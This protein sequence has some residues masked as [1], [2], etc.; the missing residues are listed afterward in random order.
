VPTN[1]KDS[2][3][4]SSDPF[5]FLGPSFLGVRREKAVSAQAA[6]WVR[7]KKSFA[8]DRVVTYQLPLCSSVFHSRDARRLRLSEF[9]QISESF[10]KSVNLKYQRAECSFS[11]NTRS[12]Q[13]W[14]RLFTF[15]CM[16]ALHMLLGWNGTWVM[17]LLLY[18]ISIIVVITRFCRDMC[19]VAFTPVLSRIEF[20][21]EYALFWVCF[22]QT[23]TQTLTILLRFCADICTK[24]WLLASLFHRLKEAKDFLGSYFRLGFRDLASQ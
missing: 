17:I 13:T 7:P 19:F 1:W 21:R 11:W 9:V 20:C 24:N 4:T 15:R 3:K 18:W 16:N 6:S 8:S 10:V 2:N 14:S 12:F 23:F 22:V 5:N